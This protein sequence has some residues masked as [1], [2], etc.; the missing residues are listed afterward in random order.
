MSPGRTLRRLLGVCAFATYATTAA[1]AHD[2][3]AER[4]ARLSPRLEAA[5]ARGDA[6]LVAALLLE[7]AELHRIERSW[8]A[9]LLDLAE[10][11]R[12]DASLHRVD[13]ARARVY[14]DSG[15]DRRASAAAR[16]YLGVETDDVA[17]HALLAQALARSGDHA[18]AIAAF[19]AALLR[20]PRDPNLHFARAQQSFALGGDDRQ[21]A[22]DGLD[23][24]TTACGGAL[25]L[26][27]LAVR[28]ETELGATDAAL[29]RVARLESGSPRPELWRARAVTLL[30]RSG[31]FAESREAAVALLASIDRLP[32]ATR[33]QFAM[34]RLRREVAAALVRLGAPPRERA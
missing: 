15:D 13:L 1:F 16:T 14:F 10:A 7:R 30:E 3:A 17:G 29:R 19:D 24:G 34:Q 4:L 28:F 31:R 33:A 6:S 32:A 20:S 23:R 12:R 27:E 2:G 21:R 8:R 5:H 18:G 25:Q 22:I 11:Q 26:E 9:A